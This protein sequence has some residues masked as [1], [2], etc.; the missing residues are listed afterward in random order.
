MN[1]L[2]SEN[3]SADIENSFTICLQ[4]VALIFNLNDP[5]GLAKLKGRISTEY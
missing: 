3:T 1:G 5:S 4:S 2:V